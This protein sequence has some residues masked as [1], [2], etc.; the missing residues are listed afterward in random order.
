MAVQNPFFGKREPD[1]FQSRQPSSALGGTTTTASTPTAAPATRTAVSTA[2]SAT[3]EGSGS[4]LTVGPNIKLKG[5]EI[6]DCD[7]LV[8]EGTVEATMDSRVIQ[9]TEQGA[10][11]GSAEID[12]AEIHGEFDGTLTVRQKLVIFSTGKVSGKIRYGKVVIEEGGQLS[13]EIEVGLGGGARM[14]AASGSSSAAS[15]AALAA[16]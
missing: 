6:T 2:S 3:A 1:T 4:K 10:F 9:I 15:S 14:S 13:G 11:R 16:A 5:V 8:V 7:T 12:I